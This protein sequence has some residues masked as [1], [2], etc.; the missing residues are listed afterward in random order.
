MR[1]GIII[2]ILLLF[3]K[4]PDVFSLEPDEILIIANSDI[5]E[6]VRLARYYCSQRLVPK[7]N[8]LALALGK[9][10]DY[11]ISRDDYNKKIAEPI[12]K[13]FLTPNFSKQGACLQL[14]GCRKSWRQRN[15]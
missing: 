5:A 11:E 9:S 6:S 4:T 3:C 14:T 10:L 1:N 13:N 15:D 2:F 12:R 7:K 8:I